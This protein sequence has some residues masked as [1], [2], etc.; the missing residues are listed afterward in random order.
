MKRKYA[1]FIIALLSVFSLPCTAQDNSL[2]ADAY[3]MELNAAEHPCIT[4]PQSMLS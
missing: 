4:S 1:P 3:P 2:D